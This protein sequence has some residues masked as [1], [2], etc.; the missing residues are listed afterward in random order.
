MSTFPSHEKISADAMVVRQET[1]SHC[2][3]FCKWTINYAYGNL[4]AIIWNST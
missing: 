3:W 2:T 1:W 4:K